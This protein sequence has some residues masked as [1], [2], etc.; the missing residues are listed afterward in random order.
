MIEYIIYILIF[1]AMV[2]AIIKCI[3]YKLLSEEQET[4]A[5]NVVAWTYSIWCDEKHAESVDNKLRNFLE[6]NNIR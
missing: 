1:C 6:S 2:F 5:T 4:K 3:K